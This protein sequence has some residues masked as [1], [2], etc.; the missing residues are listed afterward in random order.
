LSSSG[1]SFTNELEQISFPTISLFS[2]ISPNAA[3]PHSLLFESPFSHHKIKQKT[4]K[5]RNERKSGRMRIREGKERE[6]NSD[7]R[8]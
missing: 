7:G 8:E 3:N 6:K 5:Q 4:T 1:V 2:Q